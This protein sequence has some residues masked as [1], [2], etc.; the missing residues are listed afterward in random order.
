MNPLVR[1]EVHLAR[2][3]C[4]S[5]GGSP[6]T[7]QVPRCSGPSCSSQVVAA[8]RAKAGESVE[9]KEGYGMTETSS[10][11]SRTHADFQEVLGAG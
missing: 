6:L 5:S 4:I 10:C 7:S 9:M 11:V 1:R 2:A 8:M 3:R